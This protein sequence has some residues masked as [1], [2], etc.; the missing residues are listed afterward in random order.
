MLI[1][2]A[3]KAVLLGLQRVTPEGEVL[4][5]GRQERWKK[6]TGDDVRDPLRYDG[7]NL[8]SSFAWAWKLWLKIDPDASSRWVSV[9]HSHPYGEDRKRSRS[10]GEGSECGFILALSSFR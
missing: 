9:G 6:T 7:S 2:S 5:P 10:R 4:E 1:E 3:Q 8:A